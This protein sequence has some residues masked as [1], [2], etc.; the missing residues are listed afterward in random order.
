MSTIFYFGNK[1]YQKQ[2]N[3][4]FFK[5]L[6]LVMGDS[7]D[8]I[9]DVFSETIL[10]LLKSVTS[11]FFSKYSKSYNIL[12]AES[13]DINTKNLE[14]PS[15]ELISKNSKN[16]FLSTICRPPDGDFKAFNTFLKD[17]YSI[18]LNSNKL[19]YATGDLNLSV[20]DYSKNEKVTKF[21]NL[22]FEYG[23][24]PV[25]SYKTNTSY[26][27]YRECYKSYYYKLTIT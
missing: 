16:T 25:I 2:Q 20:L 19:F 26:K 23:F 12:N 22:T 7:I 9:F 18:S 6:F 1:R 11:Q 21:L 5:R 27:K 24:V 14:S 15:I 3:F 4:Q 17:V 8:M 10:S 13:L